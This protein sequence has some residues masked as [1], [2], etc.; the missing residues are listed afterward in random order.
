MAGALHRV[1]MFRHREVPVKVGWMANTKEQV[2]QGMEAIAMLPEMHPFID[3]KYACAAAQ[4]DW[5]DVDVLIVDECHHASTAPTWIE[6]IETCNGARWGMTATLPE[7]EDDLIVVMS[8]FDNER[9]TITRDQVRDSIAPAKVIMISASDRNLSPK[10]D[11]EIERQC[12]RRRMWWM[13]GVIKNK[14]NELSGLIGRSAPEREIARCKQEYVGLDQ[15]M[16]SQV[17]WQICIDMGI[18]RNVNRNEAAISTAIHHSQDN[19]LLLVNQIEHGQT[20]ADRIPGS[21]VCHSKMGIKKRREAMAAFRDGSL[22]CMIATSLADE[23]LDLPIANVLIMVSGGRSNA[24]NE[25]RTGRVLRTFKDK[26]HGTIYD[27]TDE[28]VHPL[29]AKHARV[30]VDLYRRLGY[31]VTYA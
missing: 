10:M 15:T 17:M 22:K 28:N 19:V 27:F 11:F 2:E 7:N 29:M 30:R 25:Q 23:G 21:L 16:K 8:L 24:K 26:T 18:V 6:Q 3:V 31:A 5:S 20:L 12:K 4:T 9:L 14:I 1:V 13:G